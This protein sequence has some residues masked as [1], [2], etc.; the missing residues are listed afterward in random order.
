MPLR[1]LVEHDVEPRVG[2]IPYSSRPE[3]GEKTAHALRADDIPC[4][5]IQAAV[6]IVVRLVAH[7][8][9]GDGHHDEAGGGAGNRTRGQICC[10]REL[11]QRGRGASRFAIVIIVG[12]C[13]DNRGPGLR[14]A[15]AKGVKAR[16]VEGRSEAG[17]E[18]GGECAAP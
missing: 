3:A 10:V 6:R 9:H 17:S 14:E 2:R 11:G 15:L 16:E 1:L 8:D 13:E 7:L 12:I 4:G 5:A 18:S